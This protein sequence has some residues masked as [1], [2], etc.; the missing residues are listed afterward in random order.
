M[1]YSVNIVYQN[2][3]TE[4]GGLDDERPVCSILPFSQGIETDE[5]IC[6]DGN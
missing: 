5:R 1:E 4:I 2:S 6:V 3:R